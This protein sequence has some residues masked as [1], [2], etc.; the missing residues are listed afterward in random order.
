MTQ[1]VQIE[2]A[3]VIYAPGS[4]HTRGAAV[5]RTRLL[6]AKLARIEAVVGRP[7]E[8]D[9]IGFFL[10]R[11]EHQIGRDMRWIERMLHRVRAGG[12][13]GQS[14]FA[15]LVFVLERLPE[16]SDFTNCGAPPPDTV[17]MAGP[18][19]PHNRAASVFY[20]TKPGTAQ[21]AAHPN[22]FIMRRRRRVT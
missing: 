6:R 11:A 5:R 4:P 3:R 7:V 20:Q 17:W 19:S 12:G 13:I 16:G 18:T 14:S 22:P 10:P 8:R 15:R 9:V 21:C 1:V 2:Q